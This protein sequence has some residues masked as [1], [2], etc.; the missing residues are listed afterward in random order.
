MT[1]SIVALLLI[2]SANTAS[3]MC[4]R[5]P[6]IRH[7]HVRASAATK[8]LSFHPLVGESL[9]VHETFSMERSD[10]VETAE[11]QGEDV[12][13]RKKPCGRCLVCSCG[14]ATQQPTGGTRSGIVHM[15]MA[16]VEQEPEL[17]EW[18]VQ[19]VSINSAYLSSIMLQEDQAIQAIEAFLKRHPPSMSGDM[20]PDDILG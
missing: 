11:R 18:E 14:F 4:V 17:L 19:M 1:S 20:T 16:E 9:E 10:L 3:A 15:S 7:T 6:H 5:L 12:G 8:M 2:M 13:L